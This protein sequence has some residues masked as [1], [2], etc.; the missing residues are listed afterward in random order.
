MRERALSR[1]D[2]VVGTCGVRVPFGRTRTER[3]RY[4]PGALGL[5]AMRVWAV[6]RAVFFPHA[7]TFDSPVNSGASADVGQSA[8]PSK[9]GCPDLARLPAAQ[10]FEFDPPIA[11]IFGVQKGC[12]PA[13][14]H[15]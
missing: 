12:Q 8:H 9:S 4:E 2:C 14:I 7:K 3:N 5:T 13:T 11:A 6:N 1:K 15:P 10:T